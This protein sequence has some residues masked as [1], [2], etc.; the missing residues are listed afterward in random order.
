MERARALAT[1]RK[2]IRQRPDESRPPT[3]PEEVGDIEAELAATMI[4]MDGAGL[5]ADER[6]RYRSLVSRMQEIQVQDE[7]SSDEWEMVAEIEA[8]LSDMFER[9]TLARYQ[10]YED[11]RT[12]TTLAALRNLQEMERDLDGFDLAEHPVATDGGRL[13]PLS[14]E[15]ID[16]LCEIINTG[17]PLR[18]LDDRELATTLAA[19]REL[20][21]AELAWD[22]FAPQN[23]VATDG[24]RLEPMSAEEIDALCEEIN[25]RGSETISVDLPGTIE[26]E[27]GM[28]SNVELPNGW[29]SQVVDLD[30]DDREEQREAF[31]AGEL[32]PPDDHTAVVVVE[33]G[34]VV[35]V[36]NAPP[37]GYE[38]VDRDTLEIYN[39]YDEEPGTDFD[40]SS[41]S[42]S[43]TW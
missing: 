32:E 7:L 13:E 33:G 9:H 5:P 3:S 4:Q 41:A 2:E 10:Q 31:Y 37:G 11:R 19:L 23:D 39:S 36:L 16:A 24:G 1:R 38:V 42:S 21:D 20:Q 40:F 6:D 12:A 28:V 18:D 30:L 27:G 14:I 17:K 22:G 8:E 29:S 43:R 34:R 26:V 25:A 35:D 15:E